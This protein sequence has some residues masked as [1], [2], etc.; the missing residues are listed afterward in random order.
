VVPGDEA[1]LRAVGDPD[2][3]PR[4]TAIV[5]RAVPGLGGGT[6]G[7]ATIMSY[8]PERVEIDATS[9]GRG[10]LVLS[11][12]HY[13]GWKA[14]VD[15]R[16]VDIERVDYLLRGVPLDDGE[17]TVEFRYEPLSWRIGWILSLAGLAVLVVL[18]AVGRRRARRT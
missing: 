8:E 3:D 10:L 2:F 16:E 12:L 4:R 13:P 9:R 18:L 14:E 17:H 15:G 1:T 7:E 6:G 5:E 11:D